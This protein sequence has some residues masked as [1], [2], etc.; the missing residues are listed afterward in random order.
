[1][2][3]HDIR[4][5]FDHASCSKC[6]GA[7]SFISPQ[8]SRPC[9]SCSGSGKTLTKRGKIGFQA[10]LSIRFQKINASEVKPGDFIRQSGSGIFNKVETIK[11]EKDS[12]GRIWI[13]MTFHGKR[14]T[15]GS[16]PALE[17]ERL[18]QS[19]SI[20]EAINQALALS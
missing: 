2:N 14:E 7:G 3:I 13:K 1:M 19:V 18:N 10:F 6:K 9:L 17:I 4:L 20:E 8:G 11:A 16:F 12:L 5:R 15:Y